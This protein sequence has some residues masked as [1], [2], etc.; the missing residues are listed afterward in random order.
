MAT[1]VYEY[2]SVPSGTHIGVGDISSGATQTMALQRYILAYWS[3][4]TTFT[5][6]ASNYGAY[7]T[8]QTPTFSKTSVTVGSPVF[9]VRGNGTY[10]SSSY[11][12]YTT[13]I[14]GQ[15]IIEVWKAP[16]TPIN[17][18]EAGSGL[19]KIIDDINNNNGT[20]SS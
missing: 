12:G 5:T 17:G 11:W 15:Y 9:Y 6:Y 1:Y 19:F 7:A 14:R 18:Y 13:D 16:K 20:L 10:Y 4:G 3:S 2:V 8:A